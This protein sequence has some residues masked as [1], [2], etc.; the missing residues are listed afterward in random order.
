[1]TD[2]NGDPRALGAGET[3]QDTIGNAGYLDSPQ[4]PYDGVNIETDAFD[5]YTLA[6]TGTTTASFNLQEFDLNTAT[7]SQFGTHISWMV[8]TAKNAGDATVAS[9]QFYFTENTAFL[10]NFTDVYDASNPNHVVLGTAQTG[11]MDLTSDIAS[12]L[13]SGHRLGALPNGNAGSASYSMNYE[14][15]LAGGS[16]G[17]TGGGTG[18][19]SL[20]DCGSHRSEGG[21]GNDFLAFVDDGAYM[22]GAGTDTINIGTRKDAVLV[23]VTQGVSQS[24]PDAVVKIDI[25][26]S[27]DGG[28]SCFEAVEILRLSDAQLRFDIYGNDAHAGQ[29]YRLYQAAF[30]RTPDTPGLSHNVNLMDSGLTLTDMA[31]A[32]INSAEFAQTYAPPASQSNG[33]FVNLLYQNVLDRNSD[34]A[35]FDYWTGRITSGTSRAEVLIGFS[36]SQENINNTASQL[37][38]GLWLDYT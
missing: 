17:G 3:L 13:I 36:E 34:T 15:S 1:M 11:T 6:L 20:G 16:G 18:S 2:L 4:S 23:E 21:N 26:G 32:F 14:I 24:M 28:V 12:L 8:V 25:N 35:G 38:G 37:Q 9:K 31:S 7:G 19:G 27:G 5:T 29:S 33:D 30:D 10:Q 22:G